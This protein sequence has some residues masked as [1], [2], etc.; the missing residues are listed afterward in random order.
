MPKQDFHVYAKICCPLC[1]FYTT[2]ADKLGVHLVDK[3]PAKIL[4]GYHKVNAPKPTKS[5]KRKK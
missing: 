1:D 5:A 4:R 2:A 3:H